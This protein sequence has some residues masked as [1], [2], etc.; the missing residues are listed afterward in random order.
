MR[1][2]RGGKFDDSY[3]FLASFT[4]G[5]WVAVPSTYKAGILSSRVPGDPVLA[6]LD[7]A[8]AVLKAMVSEAL[9]SVFQLAA[10]GHDPACA[11]NAALPVDDSNPQH[12]TIGYCAEPAQALPLGH[13]IT[14]FTNERTYPVDLSYPASVN[15]QCGEYGKCLNSPATNDVWVRLGSLLS[16]G[17]HH[18]LLPG[19]AQASAIAAI[20]AGQS[21]TF[22]TSFDAP[23]A[24]FGF[25]ESGLKVF[26]AIMTRGTT[27]TSADI[28][29]K[30]LKVLDGAACLR[31]GWLGPNC[32]SASP[33]P[34]SPASA[35]TCRMS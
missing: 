26:A 3:P 35:R 12:H 31:D 5:A 32:H 14:Q 10:T 25:L 30:T 21:A 19:D 28:F 6:P 15:G 29:D 13:V 23:A 9:Q 33:H 8:G 22:T 11:P 27:L 20:P 4:N 7:W 18:V 17:N 16:P 34:P 1:R 2:G 24:F